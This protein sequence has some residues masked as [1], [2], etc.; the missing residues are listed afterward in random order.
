MR[1]K[2]ELS[3]DRGYQSSPVRFLW[4]MQNGEGV[5]GKA[6]PT[7]RRGDGT[8]RESQKHADA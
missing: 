7:T 2:L 8:Q 5:S 4:Q 3:M 6:T 1:Q